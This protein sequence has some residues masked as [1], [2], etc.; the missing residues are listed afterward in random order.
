MSVLPRL[1]EIFKGIPI[2]I[3]T[4]YFIELDIDIK[5]YM[6]KQTKKISQ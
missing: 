4:I 5:V 6:E 2:K 1:D 3:P